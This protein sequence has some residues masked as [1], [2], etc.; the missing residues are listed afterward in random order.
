MELLRC[1]VRPVASAPTFRDRAWGAETRSSCCGELV[2]VDE[3]AEQVA[4]VH[5]ESLRRRLR[6]DG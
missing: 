1:P 5:L 6:F 4:T 3:A 2:L